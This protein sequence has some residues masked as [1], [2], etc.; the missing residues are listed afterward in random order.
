VVLDGVASNGLVSASC[1]ACTPFRGCPC[2]AFGAPLLCCVGPSL[3]VFPLRVDY[4]EYLDE[5]AKFDD[6]ER[7]TRTSSVRAALEHL[8]VESSCSRHVL[9]PPTTAP[10]CRL[11][12]A[13]SPP[14]LPVDWWSRRTGCTWQT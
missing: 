14:P 2:D 8:S 13:G 9:A 1:L 4:Q 10:H 7:S 5:F 3:V 12:P 6:V 11:A